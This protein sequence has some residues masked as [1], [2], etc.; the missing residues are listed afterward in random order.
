MKCITYNIQEL[1]RTHLL[2][3]VLLTQQ[4]EES[5]RLSQWCR[6]QQREQQTTRDELYYS[7]WP[8]S[9]MQPSFPDIYRTNMKHFTKKQHMQICYMLYCVCVGLYDCMCCMRTLRKMKQW[10]TY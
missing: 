6:V 4:P 3:V 9:Q 8:P 7:P 10:L 1:L 5:D 2:K